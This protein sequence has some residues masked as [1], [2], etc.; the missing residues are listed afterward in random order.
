MSPDN[1]CFK[2]PS[3]DSY[4][5]LTVQTGIPP[6]E[7]PPVPCQLVVEPCA[8]S[9]IDKEGTTLMD[10]KENY[11]EYTNSGHI[12][13]Y[14]FN[15]LLRDLLL[16]P[17]VSHKVLEARGLYQGDSLKDVLNLPLLDQILLSP[18]TMTLLLQTLFF[19]NEGTVFCD[20]VVR[21]DFCHLPYSDALVSTPYQAT[22]DFRFKDNNTSEE[23]LLRYC[24]QRLLYQSTESKPSRERKR[25]SI[26]EKEF[27]TRNGEDII[28]PTAVFL[29][30]ELTPVRI[31]IE[32]VGKV[33]DDF[34]DKINH[35]EQLARQL[36]MSFYRTIRYLVTHQQDHG[37]HGEPLLEYFSQLLNGQRTLSNNLSGGDYP[38]DEIIGLLKLILSKIS[39]KNTFR[40]KNQKVYPYDVL[41][42]QL[43]LS[44]E[45]EILS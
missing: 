37:I 36:C 22:V 12:Q 32:M 16:K 5:G 7:C 25:N 23:M 20:K 6:S 34:I 24:A 9:D 38:P 39:I 17:S 29:P 2:P 21:R 8:L 45:S 13:T 4:Y 1:C 15:V 28:F 3:K 44:L 14:L 26:N 43:Q 35:P 11:V 40:N 10:S 27:R 33:G 18:K 31:D 30:D 19:I 41:Q 42:V